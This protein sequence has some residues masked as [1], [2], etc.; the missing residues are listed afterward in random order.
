MK[1]EQARKRGHPKKSDDVALTGR[2]HPNLT[3]SQK[4]KVKE[5]K[6]KI[7]AKSLAATGSHLVALGIKAFDANVE[8][9]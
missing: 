4:E 7:G 6:E 2:I 9:K 3:E 5:I 8:F 1:Q